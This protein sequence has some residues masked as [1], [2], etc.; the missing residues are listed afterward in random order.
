M[1]IYVVSAAAIWGVWQ[2]TKTKTI[3]NRRQKHFNQ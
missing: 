1:Y 2:K 3:D